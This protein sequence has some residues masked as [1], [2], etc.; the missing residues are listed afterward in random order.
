MEEKS[1]EDINEALEKTDSSLS[2]MTLSQS[3]F[4][5]P[6][7]NLNGVYNDTE[8]C[9]EVQINRTVSTHR[10]CCVCYSSDKHLI[11]IPQN[12]RM[13]SMIKRRIF[14]ADGNRCCENHLI[15]T[16]FY[17]EDF[18]LLKVYCNWSILRASELSKIMKNFAV[19]CDATLLDKM[20]DFRISDEQLYIYTGLKRENLI[21]L[22]DLLTSMRN[23]GS[24]TVT[25]ALITFLCKLRT[26]NSNKLI[27]A[28]LQL[29]D[30]RLVSKYCEQ[31]IQSF[32]NDVL[33]RYFGF[34]SMSRNDLIQ[35]YSSPLV[36]RLYDNLSD[37]L[38][39]I[40]DGTYARHQKS[41]N[42]E[43]QRKSYSGQKKV[44]LCKP[45][46][47]CTTNGY[48]VDMLGPYYANQNDATI[49]KDIIDTPDGLCELLEPGDVFVVDRGFRDVEDH[50]EE[51]GYRVLM[52][53]LKGKRNQLTTAE[54][55][56][57]RY[58]T[59]IRWAVEAVHGMLKQK[60]HLL[61]KKFDN[62]MLPRI[63]SFYRIASFLHNK[64]NKRLT[65]DLEYPDEIVNIMKCRKNT[66]N[67]LADEVE[68]YG[69]HRK[70]LPFETISS[71]V[72]MDFPEMTEK[73]L[74]IL[75]TGSYQ[76]KQ[77]ISYLAEM[78]DES[79]NITIQFVKDRTNILKAEVQ[80]RH[81]GRK[82]YRCF[83]EYKPNTIGWSGISRYSC[84]CANGRRTVGCCS[85]VA[86]IIFYLAHGRYLSRIP[87][88]AAILN[89]LFNIDNITVVID[90]DSDED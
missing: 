9:I 59:K 35:E 18:N 22:Q 56:A 82:V 31:V 5:D 37:K 21:E 24:R 52:P 75:F 7:F 1:H 17:E 33:P 41:S 16:R 85:H 15:N 42:N 88:P 53:A 50:L 76:Y 81:I 27:S 29:K 54:S 62:K 46:T 20:N 68:K 64:Y 26:G 43:Y 89:R 11:V 84:Q 83:I 45:F 25:Q 77:A 55:N 57:S 30:E 2:Q 23:T 71:S 63:G 60:Y 28:I 8:E 67:T 73:D 38:V 87:R 79:D 51:I 4:D 69:W 72:L 90:E 10:Y 19:E 49:M 86:A 12:A 80:S 34:R 3:S 32:E 40:C 14:I 74:K 61:D 66:D 36:E 70:K 65:S 78:I 39:L 58:V 13:Q 48:I 6:S 44:P 47:I